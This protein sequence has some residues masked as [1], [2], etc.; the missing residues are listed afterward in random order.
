[1]DINWKIGIQRDI[2]GKSYIASSPKSLVLVKS[3]KPLGSNGER[4]NLAQFRWKDSEI[5]IL[6]IGCKY[7]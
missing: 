4:G 3:K 1:L 6:D 7:G 5:T 2:P